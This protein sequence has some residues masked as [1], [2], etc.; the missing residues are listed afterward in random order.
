MADPGVPVGAADPG[1]ADLDDDAVGR[2]LRVGQLL[3]R[4]RRAEGV[5]DG[6]AHRVRRG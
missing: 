6:R 4:E 1:R 2:R 5:E 3:D